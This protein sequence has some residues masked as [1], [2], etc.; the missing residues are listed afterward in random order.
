MKLYSMGQNPL[1]AN[2]F[3]ARQE[4]SSILWN[5]KVHYCINKCPPPF[6]NLSQI[7]AV[8]APISHLLLIHINIILQSMSGSSKWSVSL[9]FPH[10]NSVYASPL[11]CM[12]HVPCLILL[13][14]ITRTIFGEEHHS[15]INL[16][17]LIKW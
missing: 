4:I 1:E 13:D 6:P 12:C 3:S 10:E 2:W 9:K 8:H 16:D 11:P 7:N 14:L 17:I 5:P 15:T